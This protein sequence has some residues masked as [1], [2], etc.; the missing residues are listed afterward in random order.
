MTN[1]HRSMIDRSHTR[2]R[3]RTS[4]RRRLTFRSPLQSQ[5]H[6]PHDTRSHVP[7][8]AHVHITVVPGYRAGQEE[9][10]SQEEG[11]SKR[12]QRSVRRKTMA[13]G[14]KT[15]DGAPARLPPNVW[16]AGGGGGGEQRWWPIIGSGETSHAPR[17][18]RRSGCRRAC[19]FTG[20]AAGRARAAAQQL[21]AARRE[22]LMRRVPHFVSVGS[23]LRDPPRSVGC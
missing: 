15:Q 3:A 13:R 5:Y 22:K 14:A 21:A 19:A 4:E 20:A 17:V 11:G 18:L 10:G 7:R 12:N 23:R 2:P 1:T 9:R 8:H 16:A 6:A